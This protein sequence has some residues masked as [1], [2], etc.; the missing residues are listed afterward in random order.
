VYLIVQVIFLQEIKRISRN[1]YIPDNND[2]LYVRYRTTGM[3]EKEFR[4]KDAIFKVHD[5][6]GQ[7]NERKKWIHFFDGVTAVLFVVSLTC[8]D[9]VPFEDV[10]D[11]DTDVSLANNMLESIKV[12]EETLAQPCFEGTGFIVF[13]NKS[14]IM[15]DKVKHVPITG[16]FPNYKG[17]QEFKP[18]VEYIQNYFLALNKIS[19]RETFSHITTATDTGNVER[20]FNDVQQCVVNWSLKNAGLV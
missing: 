11:L 20:V 18:T 8:Y 12:F 13:F 3:A 15:Q 2:I 9:E 10:T 4:I 5:V 14:D 19:S 7:R 17:P 6:G 16:A 1:D